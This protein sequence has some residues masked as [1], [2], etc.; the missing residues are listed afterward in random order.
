LRASLLKAPLSASAEPSAPPRGLLQDFGARDR[1][2]SRCVVPDVKAG[3]ALSVRRKKMTAIG[4]CR[5][6]LRP[7]RFAVGLVAGALMLVLSTH[8]A[9]AQMGTV[10][11]TVTDRG[12]GQPIEGA[13]YR[14]AR[15]RFA[16]RALA[17]DRR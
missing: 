14:P 5:R 7:T 16:S 1:L 11:G 3:P 17:I 12:T 10:V 4:S 2:A 6:L 8:T 15:R 13:R 9:A